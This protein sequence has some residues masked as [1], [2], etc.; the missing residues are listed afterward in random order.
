M[1]RMFVPRCQLMTSLRVMTYNVHGGVGLDERRD[2]ER[3]AEVVRSVDP[4]ILGVQEV[5]RRPA[6]DDLEE[7]SRQA[8]LQGK[9]T[10]TARFPEGAYGHAL[11]TNAEWQTS[12][13]LAL[14]GPSG[15]AAARHRLRRGDAEFWVVN[16]HWGLQPPERYQQARQLEQAGWLGG[17]CV[18]VGDL[19]CTP[20]VAALNRV[21]GH[22]Q[23]ATG[24][25]QRTWPAP[26]PLL[27]ID[28]I[29]CSEHFEIE[30]VW[31]VKTGRARWASDHHAACAT[32][33]FR[34]ISPQASRS[35]A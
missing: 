4:D 14:T 3:I 19:N 26:I 6:A 10:E 28:H 27:P 23:R 15:R 30:R 31:T 20:G 17:P 5:W 12:E 2:F 33:R 25:R 7:L 24:W 16:M 21:E 22:L 1:V 9:F 35:L 13:R 11:L 8:K 29:F 34:G 18:V 32:L